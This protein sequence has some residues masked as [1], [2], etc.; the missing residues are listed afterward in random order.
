MLALPP[1]NR[2]ASTVLI[3]TIEVY[4]ARKLDTNTAA[5]ASVKNPAT[6]S[7]SASGRSPGARES[8]NVADIENRII[9][10]ISG[11]QYHIGS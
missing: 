9:T 3:S 2:S 4:S 1:R 5:P 7:D 11:T 8:S 10:G 6:S